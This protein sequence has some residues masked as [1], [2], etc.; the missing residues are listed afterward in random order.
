MAWL[1]KIM[2]VLM[3]HGTV[4]PPL[5]PQRILLISTIRLILDIMRTGETLSGLTAPAA[6]APPPVSGN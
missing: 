5:Y 3:F 4:S 1:I 2:P 6:W